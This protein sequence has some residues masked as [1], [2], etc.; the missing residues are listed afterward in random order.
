MI[1]GSRLGLVEKILNRDRWSNSSKLFG[2]EAATN[3]SRQ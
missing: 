1:L 2:L 3:S